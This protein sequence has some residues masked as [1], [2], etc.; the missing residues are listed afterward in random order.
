MNGSPVQVLIDG[1]STDNFVKTRVAKF[2]QLKIEPIPRFSV[3]VG[4]GQHLW[5]EGVSR[6]VPLSIQG[7]DIFL[8]LYVLSLHGSDVVLGGLLAI[9]TRSSGH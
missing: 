2:L 5:C 3:V 7:C 9:H 6:K 4:S 1:G 8:D